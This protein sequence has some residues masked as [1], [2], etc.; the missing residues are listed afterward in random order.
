MVTCSPEAG[1]FA[2]LAVR[3]QTLWP[4]GFQCRFRRVTAAG[5]WLQMSRGAWSSSQGLVLGWETP[6]RGLWERTLH[7]LKNIPTRN[8]HHKRTLVVGLWVTKKGAHLTMTFLLWSSLLKPGEKRRGRLFSSVSQLLEGSVKD[9]REDGSQHLLSIYFTPGTYSW[10]VFSSTCAC[11]PQ[12]KPL[13]CL[14]ILIV[15]RS[16]GDAILLGFFKCFL[17][18]II[19][20]H[21]YFRQ[22]RIYRNIPR[23]K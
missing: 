9:K 22:F 6:K 19:K 20:S 8:L 10:C 23:R 12:C 13:M 7:V 18:L 4:V 1:C 21:V 14:L 3:L 16:V 5:P 11:C 15:G 2:V 17:L